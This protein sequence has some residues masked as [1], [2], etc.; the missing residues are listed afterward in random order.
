MKKKARVLV[1][2]GKFD[3]RI[4]FG[5]VHDHPG[6]K[7]GVNPSPTRLQWKPTRGFFFFRRQLASY[8]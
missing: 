6:L 1:K 8:S 7:E 4:G 5:S 2:R 3:S